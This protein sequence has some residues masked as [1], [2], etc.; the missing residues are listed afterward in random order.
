MKYLCWDHD[1]M[2]ADDA[3]EYYGLN[4]S[5]AAKQ[6][7]DAEGEDQEDGDETWVMVVDPDGVRTV[8]VVTA[9]AVMQY[10][11]EEVK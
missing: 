6:F 5:A 3:E 11:A 4:A 7:V 2:S 10:D 9:R 1:H 8:F